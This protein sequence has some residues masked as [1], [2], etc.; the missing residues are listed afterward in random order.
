MSVK[1][2]KRVFYRASS[3]IVTTLTKG[4][5]YPDYTINGWTPLPGNV[6]AAVM[7]LD[8][9][10]EDPADGGAS[11]NV[12]AEK[13]VNE[14]TIDG[15][16]AA[17]YATIRGLKNDKLDILFMDPDQPEESYAVFGVRVYP[18]PEFTAGAVAKMI[19]S[20]E[21]KFGSSISTEPMQIITVS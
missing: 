17:E 20:G 16:T 21:R 3:T 8:K 15:F 18:K 6:Q 9:E 2:Y 13:V 14:I 11:M 7:N 1:Y 5:T 19:I 12:N 4:G 10:V